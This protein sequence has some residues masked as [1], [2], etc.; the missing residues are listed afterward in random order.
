MV[1]MKGHLQ[2]C[3]N[4]HHKCL[5]ASPPFMPSRILRLSRAADG[6]D[7]Y[8]SLVMTTGWNKKR[9]QIC[10]Y[11]TLSYYWGG[12]QEL[13]LNAD[14]MEDLLRG[15]KA[16][17]L[18]QT[19]QDAVRVTWNLGLQFIWIDCLCIRQDDPT[20]F[21]SEVARLPAIYGSSYVTI[22]AARA[23]HCRQGF[24]HYAS[25]PPVSKRS[26][27]LPF[28]CPDGRRGSIVLSPGSVYRAPINERA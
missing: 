12:E 4:L 26:F 9:P 13:K 16:S 28:A 23:S 8:V 22:S 27:K 1:W 17:L 19:L 24:L 18:P 14:S 21:A 10:N 20:E 25:L 6:A 15:I 2:T 3:E 7:V 11:S 5:I